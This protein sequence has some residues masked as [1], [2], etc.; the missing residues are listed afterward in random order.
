MNSYA[1]T[2]VAVAPMTYL[3]VVEHGFPYNANVVRQFLRGVGVE[4]RH[5]T[6]GWVE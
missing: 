5:L 1:R 4:E 3:A 6:G 2:A